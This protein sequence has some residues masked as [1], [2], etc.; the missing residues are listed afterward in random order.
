MFLYI[1]FW[2]KSFPKLDTMKNVSKQSEMQSVKTAVLNI[3]SFF[4]FPVI[5]EYISKESV[6]KWSL[7]QT[8]F[9]YKPIK[10]IFIYGVR[11]GQIIIMEFVYISYIHNAVKYS[12]F[13]HT[14][15]FLFLSFIYCLL[16]MLL[17][18]FISESRFRLCLCL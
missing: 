10:F 13:K 17:L 4:F 3:R 1:L 14:K 11:C 9:I 16:L 7:K 8:A 12:N 18:L 15:R 6:N 2:V 5:F